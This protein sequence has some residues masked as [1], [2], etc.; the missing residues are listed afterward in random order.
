MTDTPSVL[1]GLPLS[2][3]A[4]VRSRVQRLLANTVI[5]NWRIEFA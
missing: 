4:L 3:N 1:A 5:E 2:V